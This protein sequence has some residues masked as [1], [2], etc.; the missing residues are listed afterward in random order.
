MCS[1]IFLFNSFRVLLVFFLMIRRPPRSTR[2]DT[3]FP[4]TT[5]FRSGVGFERQVAELVDD[6]QLRLGVEAEPLLEPAIR[7]SLDQAGGQRRRGDEQHRVALADRLAAE[8]SPCPA[9]VRP[10]TSS[11]I[12]RSRSAER[13][14][15]KECVSTCR[16]RW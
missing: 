11:S 5:L 12:S 15:G 10:C 3:L 8:R 2:T 16:S 4:D 9:P 13:R 1:V 6:Q 7:V 14:V